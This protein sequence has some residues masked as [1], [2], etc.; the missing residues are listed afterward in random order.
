MRKICFLMCLYASVYGCFI[1]LSH[2]SPAP[3]ETV[4][5]CLPLDL[6]EMQARDSIYAASKRSLNLNL[7]PPRTVRMIYFLPNDRQ[8][9]ASV[10]DSMK[11]TIR[12]IQTFYGEQMQAHGHGYKTFAVESDASGEPIVHRV[13]GL[14]A[15]SYYLDDTSTKVPD[16]IH[17]TFDRDANIYM[18]V[19]DNSS[20]T[21]ST[22]RGLQAGGTGNSRGKVGGHALVHGAFSLN[23]VA[24]ELGHAFGLSHEF[25]DDSFIMSY[26]GGNRRTLSACSAGFLAVHTYFNTTVPIEGDSETGFRGLIDGV[27]DRHF[28]LIS[29]REYPLGANSVSIRLNV[30]D[31][32][33]LRMVLLLIR[34]R[35]PHPAAGSFEVKACRTLGG[36][37]SAAITF[38]YDGR[39]PSENGTSLSNPVRHEIYIQMVDLEGN[40]RGAFFSLLEISPHL[41]ATIR[42]RDRVTSVA[43]SPDGH[44]LATGSNGGT[45]NLWNV[46]TQ[47]K[48]A[49]F[50]IG[51]S[52]AFSPD[53]ESVA[54]GGTDIALWNVSRRARI[55]TLSIGNLVNSIAFSPD[56]FTLASGTWGQDRTIKLWNLVTRENIA[57]LNG[58]GITSTVAFSPDGTK[59]ASGGWAGGTIK[60][61]DVAART[62]IATLSDTKLRSV[63][64]RSVAFS[65][66]GN[67]IASGSGSGYIYE[68]LN[69]WDVRT[70][71]HVAT[72]ANRGSIQSVAFSPDGRTLASGGRTTLYACGTCLNG[73]S[74][75]RSLRQFK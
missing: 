43:F 63:S 51:R 14:H 62:H 56:G 65:P 24:H 72:L 34:T 7:G 53:G 3:D 15:D 73:Q 42:H 35:E 44:L 21:I 38:D 33:G 37:Q 45:A 60:L 49:T 16:E 41:I 47:Q 27:T 68:M 39:F 28:E 36:Q 66:D 1:S 55:A 61:W 6:E 69:L 50:G 11:R 5:F 12:R 40:L 4:H 30:S 2:A 19:V 54:V 18:I 46:A 32:D 67:T 13:D 9:R 48:T 23:T 10:V 58:N 22:S 17:Q 31:S 71:N 29:S 8:F 20:N 74:A 26:G 64:I 25:S 57:T 59:L 70:Q 75:D 52:V